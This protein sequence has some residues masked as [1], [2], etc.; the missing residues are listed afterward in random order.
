MHRALVSVV[1]WFAVSAIADGFGYSDAVLK[2]GTHKCKSRCHRITD[3]SQAQCHQPVDR[4][5]E[6]QHQTRVTCARRSERCKKCI[7]EDKIQERRIKRDLELEKERLRR[8]EA[9]ARELHE[10]DDEIDHERRLAKYKVEEEEQKKTLEQRQADLA[11]IKETQKRIQE[12]EARRKAL[13]AK[14]ALRTQAA[15]KAAC[16]PKSGSDASS[17][18]PEDAKAEWEHLKKFDGAR[19]TPMDELMAMIGLEGVKQEF[20]VIKSRVD[21]TL[22]QNTSLASERF[23]CSMLGNPGTGRSYLSRAGFRSL[24]TRFRKNHRRENLRQIPNR[25]WRNPWHV[26]QGDNWG[27][28]CES[29]CFRM[30]EAR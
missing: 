6:R 21:L 16:A 20:L 26:L 7:E 25:G 1:Q 10:L 22:R 15:E 8:Q 17:E 29:W 24:L 23:S 14:A 30:Q 28:P 9:Y 27:R 18:Y 5:C 19:S 12:Q 13:A 3:H 11:S 4:V 2:C